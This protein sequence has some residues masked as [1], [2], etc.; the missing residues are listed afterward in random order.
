MKTDTQIYDVILVDIRV[1]CMAL[2]SLN[3]VFFFKNNK[4]FH[5]LKLRHIKVHFDRIY[6]N[7]KVLNLIKIVMLW[8]IITLKV[9]I[10]YSNVFYLLIFLLFF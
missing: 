3:S 2:E 6:I 7:Y 4:D 10:I 5:K 8:E 9:S 1:L